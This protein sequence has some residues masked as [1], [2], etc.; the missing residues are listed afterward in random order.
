MKKLFCLMLVVVMSMSLYACGKDCSCLEDFDDY[1]EYDGNGWCEMKSDAITIDVLVGGEKAEALVRSICYDFGISKSSLLGYAEA[2]KTI[3][4][5]CGCV[6][7]TVVASKANY[8]SGAS[9]EV[10]FKI[11]D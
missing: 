4:S 5:P 8:L 10:I 2:V 7:A 11:Q 1:E 3:E 9:Y 6:A